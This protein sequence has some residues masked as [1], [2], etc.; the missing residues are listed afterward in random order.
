[1]NSEKKN[2]LLTGSGFV[3]FLMILL[4][5]VEKT[6]SLFVQNSN[7]D[8][9]G[10]INRI[11]EHIIDPEILI[12]GSSVAEVGFNSIHLSETCNQQV[13]NLAIDGTPINETEFLID[14][15]LSYTEKCNKIIIGINFFSFSE[16]KGLTMP[17]R[18][19]AHLSNS[20]VKNSLERNDPV[21]FNKLEYVP[22]YSFIQVDHSYYKNAVLGVF[23]SKLEVDSL[24]GFVPHDASYTGEISKNN[25]YTEEI[26]FSKKKIQSQQRIIN[27]IKAKGI[28]PILVIT[29]IFENGRNLFNN[30]SD[31]VKTAESLSLQTGIEFFNFSDSKISQDK[32][33]FYNNG[34]LNRTGA[35]EFTKQIADSLSC[36]M[37][38]IP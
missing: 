35:N 4:F 28:E 20:N 10:K 6:I 7:H 37:K 25:F 9:T 23:E 36:R 12:I 24:S 11:M 15:F 31:F 33:Y 5:I 1:M 19:L 30:Y 22:F 2:L 27:K 26:S 8:Q 18:Y 3:I 21:L 17:S 14:E 34:H 29:P 13:Y 32:K 16:K 38:Y